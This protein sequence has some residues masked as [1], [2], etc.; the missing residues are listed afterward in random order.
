VGGFSTCNKVKKAKFILKEKFQV[1]SER[2]KLCETL[3]KPHTLGIDLPLKRTLLPSGA[4]QDLK[5]RKHLGMDCAGHGCPL[6]S[7]CPPGSMR[8]SWPRQHAAVLMARSASEASHT[9][10]WRLTWDEKMNCLPSASGGKPRLIPP[11]DTSLGYFAQRPD[12]QG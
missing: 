2:D 9:L 5:R 8:R 10:T 4:F 6:R 7:R 11:F 3:P 12:L 1:F